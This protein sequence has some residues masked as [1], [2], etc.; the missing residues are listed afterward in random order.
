MLMCEVYRDINIKQT[1][2]LTDLNVSLKVFTRVPINYLTIAYILNIKL[3]AWTN[4]YLLYVTLPN[5]QFLSK[6]CTL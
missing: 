4:F 2:Y 6:N 5:N 1:I 3:Y